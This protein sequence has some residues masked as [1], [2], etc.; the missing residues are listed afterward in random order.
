V[1]SFD[2]TCFD[3]AMPLAP[4][5]AEASP[6]AAGFGSGSAPAPRGA[7]GDWLHRVALAF[8]ALRDIGGRAAL[9]DAAIAHERAVVL[10]V[11]YTVFYYC[12]YP[13]TS[14]RAAAL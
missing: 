7:A 14:A 8:E 2:A 13:L 1:T 5:E 9:S 4:A 11:P 3:I 12:S 10:E 6:A